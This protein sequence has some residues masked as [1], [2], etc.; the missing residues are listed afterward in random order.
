VE[1][2]VIAILSCVNFFIIY[3]FVAPLYGLNDE[4]RRVA[5]YDNNRAMLA[6]IFGAGTASV[7][8]IIFPRLEYTLLVLA[9]GAGIDVV[10]YL[11]PRLFKLR[12]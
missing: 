5:P 12:R 4:W 8:M 6:L 11:M 9:L 1:L 2:L 3:R 7:L 10:L